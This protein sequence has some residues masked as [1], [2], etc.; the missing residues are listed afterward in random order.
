M[1]WDIAYA[2][3]NRYMCDPV[4]QCDQIVLKEGVG[5]FAFICFVA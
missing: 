2:R 5:C 3:F 4:E 1:D